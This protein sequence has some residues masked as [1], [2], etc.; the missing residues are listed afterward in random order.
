MAGPV[1]NRGAVATAFVAWLGLGCATTPPAAG[2]YPRRGPGCQVAVYHTAIPGAALWDDLGIAEVACHVNSSLS[3]CT[4]LLKA[5]VCRMG[6]DMIYNVPREPLRP[7][8]QVLVYRGQVAHSLPG[9]P[10]KDEAAD[11]DLPPPATK[12]ESAG[13]VIPLTGLAAPA[14]APPPDAPSPPAKSP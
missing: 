2:K 11:K 14:P 7:Q 12:E 13:P 1:L 4:Q 5:E 6:G 8:D 10:V 9:N 3:Q